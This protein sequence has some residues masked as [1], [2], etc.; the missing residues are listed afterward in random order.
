MKSKR[1]SISDMAEIPINAVN[2]KKSGL[3]ITNDGPQMI[4]ANGGP[5]LEE[6][7]NFLSIDINLEFCGDVWVQ[8]AWNGANILDFRGINCGDAKEITSIFLSKWA[9]RRDHVGLI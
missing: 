3:W 2:F 4:C 1:I 5:A 7:T 8:C 6:K 9:E